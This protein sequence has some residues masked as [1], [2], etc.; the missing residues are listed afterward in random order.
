MLIVSLAIAAMSS[1]LRTE[2]PSKNQSGFVNL[3]PPPKGVMVDR[4]ALLISNSP[5]AT[6]KMHEELRQAFKE[7]DAR[8]FDRKIKVLQF[9]L[10]PLKDSPPVYFKSYRKEWEAELS[11]LEQEFEFLKR[12]SGQSYCYGSDLPPGYLTKLESNV[13]RSLKNEKIKIVRSLIGEATS[14]ESKPRPLEI[15]DDTPKSRKKFEDAP[16]KA[17][18]AESEKWIPQL[19]PEGR[20]LLESVTI[21]YSP[22]LIFKDG[23]LALGSR[24]LQEY[25]RYLNAW[26]DKRNAIIAKGKGW[27][28]GA[29]TLSEAA[30]NR[31]ASLN[32]IQDFLASQSVSPFEGARLKKSASL[33]G[34]F[35]V[36]EIGVTLYVSQSKTVESGVMVG[37]FRAN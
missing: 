17:K 27:I 16:S 18:N 13:K 37:R 22:S 9:E 28:F 32:E 4:A 20:P 26:E 15:D 10:L 36:N 7:T 25:L 29:G 34:D 14:G 19:A 21:V 33:Q 1:Q 12:F 6:K 30:R 35:R 23:K 31:T 8:E 24:I 5:D 3:E 2:D 11:N